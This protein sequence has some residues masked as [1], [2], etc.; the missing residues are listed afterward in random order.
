MKYQ[1]FKLF[2]HSLLSLFLLFTTQAYALDLNQANADTLQSIPGVGP[3]MAQRILTER[4]RGPFESLENLAE[5]VSGLGAKR[6]ERFRA[7]GLRVGSS[8]GL[9]TG[10]VSGSTSLQNQQYPSNPVPINTLKSGALK[11]NSTSKNSARAS[12][13]SKTQ[14]ALIT[15][16]IWLIDHAPSNP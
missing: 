15:P 3:K 11:S 16:E 7:A 14:P 13:S 6:I 1:P 8:T 5:R 12:K 9:R 4:A 2:R 10:L